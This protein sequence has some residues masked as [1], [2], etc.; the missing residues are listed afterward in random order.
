LLRLPAVRQAKTIKIVTI[1]LPP[2][3]NRLCHNVI[4]RECLPAGRQEAT[5]AIS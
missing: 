2:L 4:A 1:H 5:E 3:S